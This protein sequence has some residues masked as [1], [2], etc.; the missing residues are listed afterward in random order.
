MG[1]SPYGLERDPSIHTSIV[2]GHLAISPLRPQSQRASSRGLQCDPGLFWY[3][4]RSDGWVGPVR[5]ERMRPDLPLE[6]ALEWGSILPVQLSVG[7]LSG[8]PLMHGDPGNTSNA[9]WPRG[10]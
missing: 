2:L 4:L 1:S 8:V 5:E 9:W 7:V 10:E 3:F 6:L